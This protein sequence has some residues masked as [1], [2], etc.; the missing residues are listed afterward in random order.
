MVKR[1]ERAPIHA[2]AR[3]NTK[4]A[5]AVWFGTPLQ[6]CLASNGTR[7]RDQVV[8][9]CGLRN[10]FAALEPPGLMEGFA[11]LHVVDPT[12]ALA[13]GPGPSSDAAPAA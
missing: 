5:V 12:D 13:L 4:S 6:T 11:E 7:L 2:A 8:D 10:V 1:A 3:R 9:D